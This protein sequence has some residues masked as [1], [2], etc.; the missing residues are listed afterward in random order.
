M[1][2]FHPKYRLFFV[3]NWVLL[4]MSENTK[5]SAK[6][7]LML[8]IHFPLPFHDTSI[9]YQLTKRWLEGKLEG[10][11]SFLRK[12]GSS[13]TKQLQNIRIFIIV[14]DGCIILIHEVFMCNSSQ[15]NSLWLW[16]FNFSCFK[17]Y[18]LL[19]NKSLY[20]RH[21]LQNLTGLH[22][23]KL[24]LLLWKANL[25]E[26]YSHTAGTWKCWTLPPFVVRTWG[27]SRYHTVI[28]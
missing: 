12:C 27:H 23:F 4:Y 25:H 2:L 6:S 22:T 8:Y 9:A 16:P 28:W 19:K 7:I 3:Q 21:W 11:F 15:W 26:M 13:N 10:F 17:S 24:L 20:L 5:C 1:Y 14:V 18:C